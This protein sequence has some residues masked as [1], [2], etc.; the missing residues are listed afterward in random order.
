MAFRAGNLIKFVEQC[1]VSDS[2]AVGDY[3]K[4]IE[5]LSSMQLGYK[6][7]EILLLKPNLSVFLNLIGLHYCINWLGVPVNNTFTLSILSFFGFDFFFG[8]RKRLLESLQYK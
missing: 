5:E 8:R 1:M 4:A 7:V 6:D 3:L 2:L